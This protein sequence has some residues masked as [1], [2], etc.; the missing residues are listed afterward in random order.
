MLNWRDY[1]EIVSAR[2]PHADLEGDGAGRSRSFVITHRLTVEGNRLANP[3]EDRPQTVSVPAVVA[4]EYLVFVVDC[5]RNV[6][7]KVVSLDRGWI[8]P[9]GLRPDSKLWHKLDA[10]HGPCWIKET[11]AGAMEI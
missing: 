3:G 8:A 10:E 6:Q 5:S 11:E 7:L 2:V 9:S 1:E 4:G